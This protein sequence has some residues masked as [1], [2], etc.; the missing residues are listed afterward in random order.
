MIDMAAW[1]WNE[2]ARQTRPGVPG[3]ERTTERLQFQANHVAWLEAKHAA[4]RET[5]E[6]A[7]WWQK[8][9]A[10]DIHDLQQQRRAAATDNERNR[11]DALIRDVHLLQREWKHEAADE[12]RI[13][14]KLERQI[15]RVRAHLARNGT[16]L[17]QQKRRRA[18]G[19]ELGMLPPN[20]GKGFPG[21][22][23]YR[24]AASSFASARG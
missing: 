11:I 19:T 21:G 6:A 15:R 23:N 7:A 20:A 9:W 3:V 18:L 1:K 10:R 12:K 22:N 5:V 2:R 17:W 4:A 16:K 24:R 13:M 14:A 8:Q